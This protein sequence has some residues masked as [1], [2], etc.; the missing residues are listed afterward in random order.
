M[1]DQSLNRA[2]K[3]LIAALLVALALPI[4]RRFAVA[5]I[6]RVISE[7]AY[8]KSLADDA[9]IRAIVAEYLPTWENDEE[10]ANDA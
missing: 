2:S 9:R 7:Q 5:F 3:G 10:G 4:V 8:F 6:L 1:I